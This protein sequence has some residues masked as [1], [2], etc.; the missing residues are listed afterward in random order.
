[1]SVLSFGQEDCDTLDA[2]NSLFNAV[3]QDLE[4][5][6][7]DHSRPDRAFLERR[8]RDQLIA[9]AQECGCAD[10]YGIGV[11]RGFKMSGLVGCLLRH[12]ETA[13]EA[14]EQNEAQRKARDWLPGAV[15]FPAIDPAQSDSPLDDSAEDEAA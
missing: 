1:M 5:S 11:L 12:I 15:R 6:M 14:A 8:T 2:D 7:R 3:A 9:I 4:V 10:S 13:Q